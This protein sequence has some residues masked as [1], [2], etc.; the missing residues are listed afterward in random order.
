[1]TTTPPNILWICTDQQ[2]YDTIRALGNARINTPNIDALIGRGVAFTN[3][4]VQ[5]PVC[6]PSRAS[7]LTGR[8]PRTTR[9]RQNGQTIPADERLL[10]KIFS[11]AGYVCGLAGKLHLASCSDGKIEERADDGYDIFHW[12]HHPQPDWGHANAYTR[13]LASKGK[14]WDEL[15]TGPETP[16]VK[17]GIPAEYHQTTWCAE[18]T[19]AFI[20]EHGTRQQGCSGER[21]PWMIN[22]NCFDPHH[23]FDPPA[24]YLSRYDPAEM[25]LPKFRPGELEHKPEYQKLDHVWAHNEPG[26]FH[27]AAMTDDDKRQVCAAYWAMVE[28]ID[29]QVGRM[30]AALDESG[31]RDDTLVIFMSDHGEMLGDHGIYLKGPHFYDAMVHV[32]LVISW[33]GHVQED[34]RADAMVELVDLAPTLLD[35]AGIE[36]PEAM[37][38]RSL[39]PILAGTTSA[40]THRDSVFSEYYNA[41]THKRSYGTMLRTSDWKIVVYHGVDEGE[42]Y[43]LRSD[44]DEF[45]NLWDA[46]AHATTKTELLKR[47]FDASVLT[48]DPTPPRRGPF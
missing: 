18:M 22:F 29:D 8:Y 37:Q 40:S 17:H 9:L 21:R 27:V 12:S 32:P 47:C 43:D 26:Y 5:S 2:R 34:L 4:Y 25:P 10:G 39:L 31:Q 23:P 28:L 13:W 36:I 24:E 45:E 46:S 3:A 7:F 42:L 48:M 16:Y 14:T 30:L 38:G 6:A 35:A 11:E 20:R 44:P 41:W 33:P 15:Y 1:M 19:I